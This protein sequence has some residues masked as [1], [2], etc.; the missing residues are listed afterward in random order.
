MKSLTSDGNSESFSEIQFPKKDK[1]ATRWLS[2]NFDVE[3][4]ATPWGIFQGSSFDID[5]HLH[6]LS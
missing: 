1:S 4:N 3:R 5:H 6:T 2:A